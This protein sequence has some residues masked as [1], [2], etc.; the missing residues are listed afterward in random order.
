MR[1]AE[2]NQDTVAQIARDVTVFGFNGGGAAGTEGTQNLPHILGIEL[3]GHRRRTEIVDR[4]HI[5][6]GTNQ[7]LHQIDVAIVRRPMQRRR[8]V[9]L[10]RV[11]VDALFDERD[12]SG[13]VAG[14][15]RVNQRCRRRTQSRRQDK[16]DHRSPRLRVSAAKTKL[17]ILGASVPQCV[18]V[19]DH[20][21]L[22]DPVLLP[23]CCTGI[24]ARC[25]SVR[26]R[27]ASGVRS[28]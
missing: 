21:S 2:V 13:F 26:C 5:G 15:C 18:V 19:S 25:I 1:I 12:C 9:G 17:G 7:P 24:P 22:N 27:F 10:G 23:T 14:L 6:A 4:L 16:V 20:S 8:A 11:D 28:G 3:L